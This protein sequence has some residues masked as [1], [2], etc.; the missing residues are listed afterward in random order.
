MRSALRL[1]SMHDRRR[2]RAADAP[3]WLQVA[4]GV[5]FL[6]HGEQLGA[7]VL[8][9]L[10]SLLTVISGGQL[11]PEKEAASAWRS[12]AGPWCPPRAASGQHTT[13]HA[14]LRCTSLPKGCA[15]AA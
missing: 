14:R 9:K 2:R 15:A 4:P 1:A 8:D 10:N 13:K 7:T 5:H 3:P 12:V 11:H 6:P